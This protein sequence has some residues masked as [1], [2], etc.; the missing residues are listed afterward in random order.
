MKADYV[1]KKLDTG[2]IKV[3]LSSKTYVLTSIVE[4]VPLSCHRHFNK[5]NEKLLFATKTKL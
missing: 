1:K 2:R 4:L 5:W 3:A